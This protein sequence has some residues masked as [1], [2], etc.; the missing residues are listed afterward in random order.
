MISEET[1]MI[2]KSNKQIS[3]L[4]HKAGNVL[5]QA[6]TYIAVIGITY[7]VAYMYYDN[8]HQKPVEVK[9]LNRYVPMITSTMELS[10]LDKN[11]G[12]LEVYSDSM[13][14]QIFNL[15]TIRKLHS[16]QAESK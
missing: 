4:Y 15:I 11:T 14:F 16:L 12:E 13:T 7:F 9:N 1:T 3:K 8:N 2:A 5:K 6:L 10:I